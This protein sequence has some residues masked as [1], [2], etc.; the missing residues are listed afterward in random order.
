VAPG[1]LWLTER[2][3]EPELAEDLARAGVRYA[4]VDDRHF[5]VTGFELEQL[6]MPWW[7]ESDGHRL[8][9]FPIDERLRYLIPFRPPA[10]TVEYLRQLRAGG[11]R[12]A[13][14][15]DDGEKFGGWP[16]T[17]EWVYQR[18]W[19][20]QFMDAVMAAVET[21]EVRLSTLAD[22]LDDVPASGPAYLPTA[23][24][25]EM[26][27][28]SLPP[29]AASRLRRL[30]QQLG[31]DRMQ[32]PE[33]TL[34]RGGHWRNF[35]TRY[36]E[37]NRMHK[38]MQRLS[39]RCREAGDPA[40]ARRAIGR[41]QC[42]D[43]YWH[44]VFGGLYLPHLR[45]AVW[46]H[47]AVA[48][49]ELRR[50]APLAFETGDVDC[51]GRDE[52]WIHSGRLSAVLSPHRGAG[53]EEFT[54]LE[55]GV[56]YADVL[57]RRWEPYHEVEPA[58]ENP[59]TGAAAGTPSI[60]DIEARL[61]ERPPVDQDERAMFLE[62]VL[63]PH[64]AL[65]PYAAGDYAATHSWARRVF[66]AEPAVRE[67]CLE[68]I[69][70]PLDGSGGLEK[71]FAFAPGGSVS[72]TYRWDAAAFPPGAVFTSEISLAHAPA[73]AAEPAAE[74]WRFP[75]KTVSKS[76]RGFDET[77]QGESVTVRWPVEAGQG[78]IEVR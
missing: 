4:L 45:H 49:H 10:E 31:P 59:G 9:L 32:G 17:Y 34:V 3:W 46:R 13:V 75:V 72:V 58:S 51:D 12:L 37:S 28:W 77:V 74:V 2:V 67:G 5:L 47:L 52:V 41:A 14:L 57:T 20:A 73:I 66:R 16:G 23:S 76:E 71:R 36:P 63:P 70:R 19:L 64:L 29:R 44:G 69:C 61:R 42:N 78:R 8:A 1:G 38:K 48:E 11:H 21:G 6:H 35:L 25:R 50:D 30:E 39:L 43:A 55:R 33:G 65:D 22:A 60:H 27:E 62:R 26:E 53:L 54:L 18:G 7:T 56:N 15:A 68:V 24:Y 40:G